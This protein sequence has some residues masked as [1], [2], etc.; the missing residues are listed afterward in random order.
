[1]VAPLVAAAGIG[2][3][4]SLIGGATGGKGAKKAARIQQQT[5]QQQ[6]AANQANLQH[7]TGL[8]QPTIDRGNAAGTIYGGLL[9]IGDA[10]QAKTALA[11]WR[12]STGYQDVLNT[13]LNAVNANAYA[14]GSA[15][16]GATQKALLAKGMALADQNQQT[17]LGN[18]NTLIQTGNSAIGNVA[19]VS[20][21][22][23]RGNAAAAQAG[24]DA[25]SNAA[26]ASAGGW[27][28]ALRNLGSIGLGAA[29]NYGSSYT[30][31]APGFNA[32]GV[33]GLNPSVQALISA[34]GGI[35]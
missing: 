11:T 8:A 15:D 6:I 20:T 3:V 9:G 32:A 14:S 19:G 1:M 12:G 7:I 35:F 22:T 13:G 18:L 23:V 24:A 5:A 34:N 27:Q 10:A 17:Y 16:S 29:G 25:S 30:G 4:G 26:L 31:L 2:A 33:S 21:D 28:N